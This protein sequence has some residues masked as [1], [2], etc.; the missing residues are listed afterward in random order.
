MAAKTY[1]VSGEKFMARDYSSWPAESLRNRRE[2]FS[3]W[4]A[5]FELD[6]TAA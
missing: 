3:R 5:R 4:T 2:N 6:K 1:K